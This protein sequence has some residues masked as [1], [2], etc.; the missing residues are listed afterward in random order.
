MSIIL[1]LHNVD[2]DMVIAETKVKALK[3]DLP[4]LRTVT[5]LLNLESLTAKHKKEL[6]E[7]YSMTVSQ[8][9]AQFRNFKRQDTL[10]ENLG[11]TPKNQYEYVELAFKRD[12]AVMTFQEIFTL[13]IPYVYEGIEVDKQ[14]FE[15]SDE[16]VQSI[17][18][19][20]DSKVFNR[21]EIFE[22][23]VRDAVK[24]GLVYKDKE[25]DHALTYW[26]KV[27]KG[28]LI[29]KITS[30]VRFDRTIDAAIE[31]DLFINSITDV[32][33][34]HAK[35]VLQHFIWQVK[36]KMFGLPVKYHMM[37]ILYGVKQ[38]SGK[39][40]TAKNFVDP[41]KEFVSWTDFSSISDNRD[42]SIWQNSVLVFDEMGNSTTSNLE[43]IKQRL[44]SDTFTSRVMNTNGNSTIINKTTSLGT[45]NK[46]LTRMIFD[47]SGMRRFYQ[48]D[49]KS[50]AV[51]DVLANID[52]AKL[53][54]SVDENSE[55]PLLQYIDVFQEIQEIQSEKR[56]I[57]LIESFLLDRKYKTTTEV[58]CATSFFNEFQEYEKNHTP[59]PEMTAAKFGR[60]VLDIAKQVS[61]LELIKK[62]DTNGVRYFI[63]KT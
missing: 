59:R 50:N 46:D 4:E 61:G 12:N 25:I 34:E 20:S 47:E 13:D 8:L 23:L 51:W 32:N 55:T 17:V 40:T 5:N 39:S 14:L 43:I 29:G 31:W 45:T 49:F 22:Y 53:W 15:E 56:F 3:D 52:Y 38:G 18:S 57:T 36:R 16:F 19:L 2:N 37:P 30:K 21:K 11:G 41:I 35:V 60:D 27:Q 26:I 62:R 63:N 48:I 6:A 54:K 10:I 9:T 24:L 44:T 33:T 28:L 1:T 7:M 58:I 42:H